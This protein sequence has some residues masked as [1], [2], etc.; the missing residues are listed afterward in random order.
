MCCPSCEKMF[1][2]DCEAEECKD[3]RRRNRTALFDY[4]KCKEIEAM[5]GWADGII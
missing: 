5:E 2:Q 1:N 3:Q 4:M